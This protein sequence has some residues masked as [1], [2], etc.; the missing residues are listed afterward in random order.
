M[1]SNSSESSNTVPDDTTAPESVAVDSHKSESLPPPPGGEQY[2]LSDTLMLK[3]TKNYIST[4]NYEIEYGQE[5][6]FEKIINYYSFDGCFSF[7]ERT[8]S[9][10]AFTYY[11]ESTMIFTVPADIVHK[12]LQEKFNTVPVPQKT[13]CY[14]EELNCYEFH[15]YLGT[16]NYD[17]KIIGKK[18]MGENIYD[19]TVDLTYS[20]DTT[21]QMGYYCSFIVELNEIGYKYLSVKIEKK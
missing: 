17:A 6:P 19:F 5:V 20:L 12:F 15:R 10:D 3:I 11:D 2:M 18:S 14:N 7:D 21:Y 4:C 13:D 1:N 16:Y 8:F 9:E